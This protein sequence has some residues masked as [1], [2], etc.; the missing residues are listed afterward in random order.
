MTVKGDDDKAADQKAPIGNKL[1]NVKDS[2]GKK[3]RKDLENAI[4]VRSSTNEVM[5]RC[6]VDVLSS[7][8]A[9]KQGKVV[10]QSKS[11]QL[12][13]EQPMGDQT[14]VDQSK[15]DQLKCVQLNCDQGK[16]DQSAMRIPTAK[17]RSTLD[18]N[19]M[20]RDACGR[21]E[22]P[23][24]AAAR[25]AKSSLLKALILKKSFFINPLLP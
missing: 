18:V 11:D 1:E 17:R 15:S 24:C 20:G 4:D 2:D 3:S 22:P 19:A 6:S 21:V 12:K 13:C 9:V 5:V 16:G 10:D 7:N 14:K 23:L 25:Q 8:G